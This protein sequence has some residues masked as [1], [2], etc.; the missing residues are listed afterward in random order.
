MDSDLNT[1][2]LRDLFHFSVGGLHRNV[3]AREDVIQGHPLADRIDSWI[4]DKVNILEFSQ[5]FSG[6]YWHNRYCSDLP[7]RKKFS[8]HIF[9]R[10]FADFISQ[11]VL[12]RIATGTFRVW[13]EVGVDEPPYLVLLLAVEFRLS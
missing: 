12:N 11:E 1:L 3:T 4:R 8:D 6:V 9:C 7:P 2:R 10:N 13:G 5:P